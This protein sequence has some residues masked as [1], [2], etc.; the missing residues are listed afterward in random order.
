MVEKIHI[1]TGKVDGSTYILFTNDTPP[2]VTCFRYCHSDKFVLKMHN[3]RQ[4][5]EVPV[6]VVVPSPW[7]RWLKEKEKN[8]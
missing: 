3:R 4:S 6:Q 1:T 8:K 5:C 7:T 2:P